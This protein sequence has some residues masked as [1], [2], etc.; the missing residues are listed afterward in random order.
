MSFPEATVGN[1]MV[2]KPQEHRSLEKVVVAATSGQRG[3][4]ARIVLV[5]T[6]GYGNEVVAS[7]STRPAN[8]FA[9]ARAWK[10]DMLGL[11]A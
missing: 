1:L 2:L 10:L 6:E 3:V 7:C 4:R 9:L 5:L 11:S 8:G